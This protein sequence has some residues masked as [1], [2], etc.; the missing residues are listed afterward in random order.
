MRRSAFAI[1]AVAALVIFP[2]I[3]SAQSLTEQEITRQIIDGFNYTNTH[4]QTRS[5]EYSQH[6]SLEFWSS[7]GLLQEVTASGR[8]DEYDAI[9]IQPKHI[10]VITLVEGQAAVAHYYSEGSMKP[11]GYPATSN[12]FV[13]VTAVYVKEDS[14]WKIRSEHFSAVLG[15]GGTTQTAQTTP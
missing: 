15:G 2:S 11:K 7:G 10:K 3:T 5:G 4:L 1:G 9:N 13:R 14:A 8:V 6:G 12:Y